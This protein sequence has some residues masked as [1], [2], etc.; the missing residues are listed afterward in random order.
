MGIINA[1]ISTI[2]RTPQKQL[3]Q[4]SPSLILWGYDHVSENHCL[5]NI[6]GETTHCVRQVL[7]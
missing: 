5:K 1:N 7:T 6:F 3:L 4:K 2:A